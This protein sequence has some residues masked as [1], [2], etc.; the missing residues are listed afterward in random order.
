MRCSC[1]TA[2]QHGVHPTLTQIYSP[3]LGLQACCGG[4]SATALYRLHYTRFVLLESHCVPHPSAIHLQASC[5][6]CGAPAAFYLNTCVHSH[7]PHPPSPR[8]RSAG[9]LSALQCT[10]RTLPD[11]CTPPPH[12]TPTPH[13]AVHLQA[14]CRHCGAAALTRCQSCWALRAA[15]PWLTCRPCGAW[16]RDTATLTGSCLTRVWCA[17]WPTTQ[18]GVGGRVCLLLLFLVF[19]FSVLLHRCVGACVWLF[20]LVVCFSVCILCVE[21]KGVSSV[22][23]PECLKEGQGT[24]PPA[25]LPCTAC[26]NPRPPGPFCVFPPAVVCAPPKKRTRRHRV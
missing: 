13:P 7:P 19:C 14:S 22:Y 17:A 15:P 8:G 21:G 16:L 11:T 24:S 25:L 18:V 23:A 5:R 20:F 2:Q 10:R 1:S 4:C 3:P 26:S 12:T 9:I 6:C